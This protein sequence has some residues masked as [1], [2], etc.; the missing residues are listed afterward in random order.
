MRIDLD[1]LD[2]RLLNCLQ[3]NNLA[4]AE[5]LSASVPLSPSAITRRIRR[6]EQ[7]IARRSAA[8]QDVAVLS[9]AMLEGRVRGLVL[10]RLHAHGDSADLAALRRSLVDTPEVQRCFEIT[11][12]FDAAAIVVARDMDSFN[13]VVDSA[14]G[15]QPAVQRFETN[16]FKREMKNSPWVILDEEM[17]SVG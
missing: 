2:I 12:P 16:F 1:K 4:T 15:D 8:N 14:I 9:P 11:G 10:I 5:E 13:E 6:L 3:A 7:A 17:T